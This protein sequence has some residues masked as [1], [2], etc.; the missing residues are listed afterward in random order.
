MFL[1]GFCVAGLVYSRAG[2]RGYDSEIRLWL[3]RHSREGLLSWVKMLV[4]SQ[5]V[6][7]VRS[8]P[9][10]HASKNLTGPLSFTAAVFHMT[11]Y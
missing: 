7:V 10:S 9:A 2:G 1:Q 11:L 5:A 6:T 3:G 8:Q 4:E